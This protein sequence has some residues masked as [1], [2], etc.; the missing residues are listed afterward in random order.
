MF[1]RRSGSNPEYVRNSQ[2][3][4]SLT[5]EI[6]CDDIQCVSLGIPDPDVRL[7]RNHPRVAFVRGNLHAMEQKW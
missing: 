3:V 7:V 2:L 4:F 1:G 5:P 6:S